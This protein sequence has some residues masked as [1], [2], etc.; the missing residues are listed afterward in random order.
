MRIERLL[1]ERGFEQDEIDA[2]KAE[3]EAELK[4][5]ETFAF[6]SPEPQPDVLLGAVYAPHVAST[7][8]AE[9]GS[10]QLGYLEAINEALRQEME[11]DPSVALVGEDIGKIG[12]IFGAT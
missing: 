10:R 3:V 4:A 2:V 7:E 11:R 1:A 8:P 6:A 9:Q 12:G 5:A